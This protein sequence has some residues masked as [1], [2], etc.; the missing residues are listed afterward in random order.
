MH[1]KVIAAIALKDIKAATR[2][3]RVA[4]AFLMP[5]G[6]GAFYNIAMPDNPK[7]TATVV[8]ASASPTKLPQVLNSVVGS[9][10]Q[11]TFHTAPDAAAARSQVNSGKADLGLILPDRFD[12]AVASGKSPSITMLR[13]PSGQQAETASMVAF[14]EAA[15]RQMAGQSTPASIVVMATA[16]AGN[17]ITSAMNVIG[18]RKFLVIGTLIMLI[19]M[20]AIYIIPVLLTEEY[21]KKTADALLMIG[22]QTDLVFAKAGVGLVFV[23]IATAI[24]MTF[25]RL[26]VPSVLPFA[27]G[28]VGLAVCLIG[29]GLLM[30]GLFRTVAQLNNWSSLPL[31]LLLAPVFFTALELPSAVKIL[32]EATPSGQAVRLLLD[33]VSSNKAFTDWPIAIAVIAGWAVVGYGLLIR[34]LSRR[35]A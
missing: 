25:T 21:E 34:S 5:I 19:A 16:P 2:D 27:A 35:E 11:L 15:V 28:V 20:I 4:L 18:V 31:L 23:A 3:G 7:L 8:V 30:G 17:D 10:A 14:V 12:E 32:F 9:A 13:P 6:L 22:N 1:F 29:F 24:F 33:G 26:S